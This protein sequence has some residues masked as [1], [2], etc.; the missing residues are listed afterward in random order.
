MKGTL[1]NY[2]QSPRKVR[3]IARALRGMRAQDAMNA[4]RVVNKKA[5][6]PVRKLIQSVMS[7][8]ALS[9]KDPKAMKIGQITVDEGMTMKRYRPRAFGRSSPI[10]RRSS[11]V[12]VELQEN[13]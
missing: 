13:I 10:R 3:I 12:R 8:A 11:T 7:N 1:K 6:E 2:R 4:L 9:G 5:A